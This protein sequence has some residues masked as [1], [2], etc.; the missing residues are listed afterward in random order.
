[1]KVRAQGTPKLQLMGSCRVDGMLTLRF[2]ICAAVVSACVAANMNG[3]YV[4]ATGY[5]LLE[6]GEWNDD[7][8]AEGH[9]YFDVWAPEIATHYGEVFWTDQGNQP[10]PQHIVERFK[11]KVMAITGYEQGQVMVVPT[12]KPG[13]NP[14]QDVLA[15]RSSGYHSTAVLGQ[16]QARTAGH[17]R[18][19][20]L[21]RRPR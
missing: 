10:I 9:E 16:G 18:R 15:H 11:G 20:S 13:L 3:Q 12:G 1:M 17:H 19:C 6:H 4:V 5:K 2:V 21:R 8:A 7:Y 14:G